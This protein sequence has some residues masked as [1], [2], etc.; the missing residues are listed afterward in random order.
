MPNNFR[1]ST[2]VTSIKNYLK[3]D[4]WRFYFTLPATF[5]VVASRDQQLS[6]VLLHVTNDVQRYWFA[7]TFD[8]SYRYIGNGEL[9]P[10][11][12][13]IKTDFFRSTCLGCAPY[14]APHTHT[15]SSF[16]QV[17]LFLWVAITTFPFGHLRRLCPPDGFHTRPGHLPKSS[18]RVWAVRPFW[19]HIISG[20]FCSTLG[21]TCISRRIFTSSRS[22]DHLRKWPPDGYWF[23]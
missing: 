5:N 13:I 8:V 19:L 11:S 17:R 3:P 16:E 6:T 2:I 22:S 1:S 18:S 23:K 12:T 14:R 4:H 9:T 7:V 10:P 20:L 21:T 15:S